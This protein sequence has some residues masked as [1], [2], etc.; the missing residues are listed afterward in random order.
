MLGSRHVP[1]QPL[2]INA[3]AVAPGFPET[4]AGV[5]VLSTTAAIGQQ[6]DAVES[7]GPVQV[8]PAAG[9][10]RLVVVVVLGPLL[11]VHAG[12]GVAGGLLHAATV[13][14]LLDSVQGRRG[15]MPPQIVLVQLVLGAVVQKAARLLRHAQVVDVQRRAQRRRALGLRVQ[16][17]RGRRQRALPPDAPPL[18]ADAAAA[19]SLG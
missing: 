11:V 10:V 7:V 16:G 19:F 14:L 12:G 3:R 8:L 13:L 1:G 17:G 6:V 18:Y 4:T 5:C 9:G 2:P 15:S